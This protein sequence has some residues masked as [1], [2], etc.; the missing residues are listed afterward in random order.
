MTVTLQLRES[1][2]AVRVLIGLLAK[3]KII[4]RILKRERDRGAVMY[5][6]DDVYGH[7]S[8]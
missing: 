4:S 3:N 8:H 2:C 7:R 6:E 1:I 5:T